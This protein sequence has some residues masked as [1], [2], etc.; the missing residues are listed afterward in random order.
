[1]AIAT[2]GPRALVGPRLDVLGIRDWFG[3]IVTAADV[4]YG[5]PHPEPFLRAAQLLG[6]DPTRCRAYE[7]APSGMESARAAGMDVVD[8]ATLIGPA[9]APQP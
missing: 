8:V 1:M 4:E 2:G 7:D 3:A 9:D 6:V 5:K